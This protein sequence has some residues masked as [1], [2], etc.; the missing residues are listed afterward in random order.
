M[1][2]EEGEIFRM[3]KTMTKKENG[4]EKRDLTVL[5]KNGSIYCDVSTLIFSMGE[6]RMNIT[7]HHRTLQVKGDIIKTSNDNKDC[8]WFFITSKEADDKVSINAL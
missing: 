4:V 3:V 1:K 8:K 5:L 6:T 7:A 2:F